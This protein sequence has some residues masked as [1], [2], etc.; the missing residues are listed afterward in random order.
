[1][2]KSA[3][4]YIITERKSGSII[5]MA[6]TKNRIWKKNNQNIMHSENFSNVQN[7]SMPRSMQLFKITFERKMRLRVVG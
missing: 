3:F 5:N 1:M 2:I 4:K 6:F 7:R